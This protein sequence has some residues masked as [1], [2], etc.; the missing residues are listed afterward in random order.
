[1][2]E[3]WRGLAAPPVCWQVKFVRRQAHVCA[4]S[5]D[6][7]EHLHSLVPPR[8]PPSL[9]GEGAPFSRRL[10]N[11]QLEHMEVALK[12]GPRAQLALEVEA[13]L[14]VAP[15]AHIMPRLV[16]VVDLPANHL[17]LV[18]QRLHCNLWDEC[19]AMPAGPASGERRLLL[20]A[21]LA[22]AVEALAAA[23]IANRDI[24]REWAGTGG[25]WLEEVAEG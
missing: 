10:K 18:L 21:S 14:R 19:C 2:G 3:G 1:M 5:W 22:L 12:L 24:K 11:P 23:G 20:L 6:Q 13:Y 8:T 25:G 15:H 4:Q 17:L 9:A 16:A 7:A